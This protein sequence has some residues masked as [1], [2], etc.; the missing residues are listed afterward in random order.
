MTC[1]QHQSSDCGWNMESIM[2]KQ[3]LEV[4]GNFEKI[5]KSKKN[6]HG[7]H[8]IKESNVGYD[9]SSILSR[10]FKKL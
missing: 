4:R 5:L 2:E 3:K 10:C 7:F 1:R 9:G 8:V 6:P